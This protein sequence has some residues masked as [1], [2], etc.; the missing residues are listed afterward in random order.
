MAALPT[1]SG[2]KAKRLSCHSMQLR[3]HRFRAG[4]AAVVPLLLRVLAGNPA[5]SAAALT[6]L[7][8]VDASR[9][10]QL[11]PAVA[12]IVVSVPWC[13]IDTIVVDAV[14]WR[15]VFPAAVGARVRHRQVG[16]RL[17][18]PAL[19]ALAGITHLD[20]R[21][22]WGFKDELLLNLPP[23]LRV[24]NV[25]NCCALTDLAS[26]V[27]LAAL[28]T[29]DCREMR[30]VSLGAAGLPASL[31]ELDIGSLP[32]GASLAHL[33]RLR[34]LRA[35]CLDAATLAS[36][37]PSLLE[38]HCSGHTRG[39][40]FAHLP[41]LQ[42]LDVSNTYILDD[43][44]LAS[45]P[46]SLVSLIAGACGNLTT[47][48]VLPPLPSLRLL[49]VS[50]TGVGDALV[51]SLPAGL[52]ELRLIGCWGGTE[53]AILNRVRAIQLLGS[54]DTDLAPG[55]AACRTLG[56]WQGAATAFVRWRCW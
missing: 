11:H 30:V 33:A 1:S 19:A 23:S 15:S 3:S 20:L 48:A 16:G 46:P 18:P 55:L 34:V 5:T 56:R 25:S 17:S 6:C 32:A 54:M 37:P 47:A 40:Q 21:D 4:E 2:S 13:D 51:A 31:L 45:M 22:C 38:L 26:F 10:R 41:A 8:T 29:L 50:G 12:G 24:L 27:H 53:S 14:Q 43:A 52:T 35:S 44:S 42:T 39:A 7:N 9:L 36:L 28:T 49:D